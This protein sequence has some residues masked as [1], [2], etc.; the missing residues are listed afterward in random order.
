MLSSFANVEE[1]TGGFEVLPEGGYVMKIVRAEDRSRD[2]FV[3]VRYE[4]AEGKYKDFFATA[5]DWAH[6]TR[7]Y[8]KGKAA[9]ICKNFYMNLSRDNANFDLAGFESDPRKLGLWDGMLFG[10]VV[11]TLKYL[12][13]K[14]EPKERREIS[15]CVRVDDIRQGKFSVPEPRLTKER[16]EYDARAAQPVTVIEDNVSDVDVPF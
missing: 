10:A 5:P 4:V 2:E 6:E 14:G 1:S 15:R 7:I 9:G 13:D 16:E 12:N 11:G 8:Y 3:A